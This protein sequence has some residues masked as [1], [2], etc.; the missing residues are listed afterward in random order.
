MRFT[1][2]YYLLLEH[3]D[4][5]DFPTPGYSGTTTLGHRG[6]DEILTSPKPQA[7][8][9]EGASERHPLCP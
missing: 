5:R 8:R 9:E 1:K 2:Y 3:P 7:P 6:R 4:F